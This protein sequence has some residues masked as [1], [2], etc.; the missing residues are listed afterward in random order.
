MIIELKRFAYLEKCTRGELEIEGSTFQTIERP[1]VPNP[2]GP[3]GYP[4]KSCIPDSDYLLHSHVRPSGQKVYI[5]SNAEKGVY[6]QAA[7]RDNSQGRYL[8]LIHPGNTVADVVGCIA[9]G[10]TGGAQIVASSRNAMAK[11]VQLLGDE[12][13]TLRISPKGAV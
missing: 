5:L 11:I 6:E 3:G 7:D 13:H 10:M 4:F 12:E 2:D 1:W 8:I 9:P